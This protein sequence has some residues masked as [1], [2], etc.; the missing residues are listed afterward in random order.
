MIGRMIE[1][2]LLGEGTTDGVAVAA[3]VATADGKIFFRELPPL[4]A[5][6]SSLPSFSTSWPQH[7]QSRQSKPSAPVIERIK[8]QRPPKPENLE[9]VA[10]AAESHGELGWEPIWDT[11]HQRIPLYRARHLRRTAVDGATD[12]TE[13]AADACDDVLVRDLVLDELARSTAQSRLIVLGLP[14]RFLT[15]ASFSRRRDYLAMLA[16]KTS[17]EM[18]KFLVIFL[19]KVPIGVPGSRLM[20]LIAAL[21]PFCRELIIET[22]L[23]TPD[24]GAL[25][26][27]KVY[28]VGADLSAVADAE[29]LLMA[30]M[31][32]FAR[33]AA[34]ARVANC[35]L[36][37]VK[38]MSAAVAAIGA[39]FRYIGG[40]VIGDSGQGVNKVQV[41]TLDELYCRSFEAQPPALPNQEDAEI[42][43]SA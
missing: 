26:S 38:T 29:E 32:Q 42:R 40:P 1:E 25:A 8:P 33:H 11:R 9:T 34:K 3:A 41:L 12:G 39:G 18:R 13:E 15:I 30:Q 5:M 6:L 17:P 7:E 37:G 23:H 24:L 27:S 22:A 4:E 16:A 28:A 2:A 21:R 20:E 31:D 43:R 35:C 36:A 19:S 14:V 10:V